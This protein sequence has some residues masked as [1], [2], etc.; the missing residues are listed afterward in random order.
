[1]KIYNEDGIAIDAENDKQKYE[2]FMAND[3]QVALGC[4]IPLAYAE[5]I[6]DID[7]INVVP[8][9]FLE[10]FAHMLAANIAIPLTGSQE[11]KNMEYQ[12]ATVA[13]Q[14]ARY[15]SA[16]E[17]EISP[18]VANQVTLDKYQYALLKAE[19]AVIRPAGPVY[20]RPGTEYIDTIDPDGL[21][22]FISMVEYRI[23]N[24]DLL[25]D[26]GRDYSILVII[27]TNNIYAYKKGRYIAHCASPFSNRSANL[28]NKL[29]FSQSGELLF[30]AS[31][32]YP[33]KVLRIYM[34]PQAVQ[35]TM[36]CTN[37]NITSPYFSDE[38]INVSDN[39][40]MHVSA[41]TGNSVNLV[42]NEDIFISSPE[43]D[44]MV[45]A[46]FRLTHMVDSVSVSKTFNST[47]TSGNVTVGSSWKIITSGT[48]DGVMKI[49]ASYDNGTS[50]HDYRQYNSKSNFN[51]TES[52]TVTEE[53]LLRM[54]YT[55][56]SGS[57]TA[58][59][60]ALPYEHAGII[61]ITSITNAR[62]AIGNVI[63]S[64][65]YTT[66]THIVAMDMFTNN[67]SGYPGTVSFFQDRL[68][69]GGTK[70]FPYMIWMSK[71]GDYPNFSVE[72]AGGTLTDDSAIAISLISRQQFNIKFLSV[73]TDMF[74]FTN[75]N[76]WVI[77]GSTTVTPT[78]IQTKLQTS[79]GSYD[80]EPLLIGNKHIFVEALGNNVREVGY[81]FNSDSYTGDNLNI[82]AS[83]ITAEDKL[84]MM[85]YKNEPDSIIFFKPS[86]SNSL[87]S[88]TYGKLMCLTYI[89]EQKVYAWSTMQTNGGIM[90]ICSCRDVK[91][92]PNRTADYIYMLTERNGIIYLERFANNDNTSTNPN[93]YCML[94]CSKKFNYSTP[95]TTFQI[96]HLPNTIVTVLGDGR[97]YPNLT[98]DAAG[99]VTIPGAGV[100]VARIGLAYTL[101][102]ELPNIE[103]RT[104]DGTMQGREKHISNCILRLSNTLG[105]YVGRDFNVQDEIKYDEILSVDNIKLFTGDK[106]ISLP[107]GGFDI[108]GRITITS[109][110]PY[111]FN[112]LM[113]VR[114][115]T[116]GG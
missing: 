70:R 7:D 24:E 95:Q 58:V 39:F 68:C 57:C 114:V 113:A 59:L 29:R 21:G 86:N 33:L 108:E 56:T 83:H 54:S 79:R 51:V 43:E 48:W 8:S 103:N 76:E 65:A 32:Y 55:H 111:P 22:D 27:G 64:F 87:N 26:G 13:L 35:P 102:L 105:G 63:K 96:S 116:F 94:D 85:S 31:G 19:N 91:D 82:L 30:I 14:D 74:I 97:A 93:D 44:T 46:K 88:K 41:T 12:L 99:N 3:N 106:R 109:S 10:A 81:D 5:Y 104:S 1:M 49:Q 40:K 100:K 89:P 75:G 42:A 107:M 2:L 72:K 62:N 15:H 101:N 80:A 47:S 6:Y 110:S 53:T 34:A 25:R 52:G 20:K 90:G 69:F 98:T 50:W 73:A 23:T 16:M 9:D 61:Q 17:R 112:L 37:Y 67:Y 77:D 28:Y 84:N 45:G 115:V 78:K 60:T 66:D 11:L 4:N 92:D 36:T 18:E 71:S 38:G